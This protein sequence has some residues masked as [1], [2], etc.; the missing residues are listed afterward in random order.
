M[1]RIII[2]ARVGSTR[3][4]EKMLIPFYN[5][6]S[7]LELLLERLIDKGYKNKV[8]VA[9]SINPSDVKIVKIANEYGVDSFQGDELNV[10][11]RF[12]DCIDKYD[13]KIIIRICA[14]N[15]L[16]DISK[17]DYLLENFDNNTDYLGFS[18]NNKPS[19]LTHLGFYPELVTKN[20]LSQ[21][22]K[23]TSD[24]KYLEHVTKY[25][26]SNPRKFKIKWLIEENEIIKNCTARFTVDTIADFEIM[27]NIYNDL[28]TNKISI[29]SSCVSYFIKDKPY[30]LKK[31]QKNILDNEK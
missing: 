6:K 12:S 8:T 2:Q 16:F 30:Y 23:L 7:I 18:V 3:L 24:I 5:D 27:R 21:V 10:T 20:S 29:S 9:T 19:I 14:D 13:E 26:Y 17:I 25:I 22:L 31:M 1:Y 15:P 4:P 11:K 28:V